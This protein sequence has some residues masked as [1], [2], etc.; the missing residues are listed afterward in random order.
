MDNPA[1]IGTE[2]SSKNRD[3]AGPGL[4]T[5]LLLS[6]QR[7]LLTPEF[8][9][10]IRDPDQSL[11]DQGFFKI[12]GLEAGAV[13]SRSQPVGNASDG[14]E[15]RRTGVVHRLP[16]NPQRSGKR[17]VQRKIAASAR[18]PRDSSSA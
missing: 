15:A 3:H 5:G 9:K 14:M 13:E 11:G 12:R 6:S 17:D 2:S 18:M 7:L 8:K 4:P 16:A 1:A 10:E